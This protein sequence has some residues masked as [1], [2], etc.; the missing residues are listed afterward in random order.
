MIRVFVDTNALVAARFSSAPS[1]HLARACLAGIGGSGE[2]LRLSLQVL[3]EYLAVTTC[4]QTWSN[5]LSME[6]ALEDVHRLLSYFEVL[7]ENSE[8]LA[9][10]L[11]RCK[12]A[13]SLGKH[14]HDANTVATMVANGETRLFTINLKDFRRF[15][16][17]VDLITPAN[18]L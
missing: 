17:E 16:R 2:P 6:E 12:S 3:R 4:P 9:A 1:H 10:F 8:V 11:S 14:I 13:P 15:S 5:P 18:I 7:E